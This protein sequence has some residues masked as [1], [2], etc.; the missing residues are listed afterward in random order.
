MRTLLV[1]GLAAATLSLTGCGGTFPIQQ[2]PQHEVTQSQS[3]IHDAV[4]KAAN[5]R[6]F[7]VEKDTLSPSFTP[8]SITANTFSSTPAIGWISDRTPTKS[9][10]LTA[11]GLMSASAPSPRLKT[12]FAVIARSISGSYCSIRRSKITL[13]SRNLRRSNPLSS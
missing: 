7:M 3:A 5:E 11:W 10:I 13:P 12:S 6:K 9:N 2:L 1:L 4:I 8:R